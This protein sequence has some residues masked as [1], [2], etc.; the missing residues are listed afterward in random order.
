MFKDIRNKLI[1]FF[2]Y[3]EVDWSYLIQFCDKK[4]LTRKSAVFN[5]KLYTLGKNR[6]SEIL[7]KVRLLYSLYIGSIIL[8]FWNRF[9]N[10]VF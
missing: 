6:Y 4:K 10:A 8:Y 5:R 7:P 9:L 1:R 2:G 3:K